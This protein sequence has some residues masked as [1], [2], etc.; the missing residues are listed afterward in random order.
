MIDRVML[1]G[2]LL[3]PWS[4]IVMRARELSRDVHG[5]IISTIKMSIYVDDDDNDDD[6]EQQPPLC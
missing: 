4:K 3:S 2:R 5:I 1:L 6:D